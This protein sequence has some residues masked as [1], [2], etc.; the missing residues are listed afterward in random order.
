MLVAT[1]PGFV[2]TEQDGQGIGMGKKLDETGQTQRA[3]EWEAAR[4]KLANLIDSPE[5]H[6][7][8]TEYAAHLNAAQRAVARAYKAMMAE[9]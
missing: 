1:N 5:K 7:P 6:L 3:G 4:T 2:A 9:R 8:V